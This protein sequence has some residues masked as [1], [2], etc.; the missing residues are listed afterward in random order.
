MTKWQIRGKTFYAPDA[1]QHDYLDKLGMR[2][3]QH[4]DPVIPISKNSTD[5]D[6]ENQN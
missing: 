5:K 6:K 4:E 3:P 2:Y 1:T